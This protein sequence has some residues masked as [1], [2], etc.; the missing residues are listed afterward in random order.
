MDPS[1]G[2]FFRGTGPF[3]KKLTRHYGSILNSFPASPE[4]GDP[5]ILI[6]P[7]DQNLTCMLFQ[8]SRQDF[9]GTY[10]GVAI[11][12]GGGGYDGSRRF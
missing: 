11:Y 7:V 5:Q 1:T 12:N 10:P 8:W 2:P 4:E 6:N 9:V 3:L